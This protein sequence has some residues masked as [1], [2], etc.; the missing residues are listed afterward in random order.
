MSK[1]N[2]KDYGFE[3]NFVT[4]GEMEGGTE[5]FSTHTEKIHGTEYS[6]EVLMQFSLRKT[7]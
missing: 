6:N 5:K 3:Y 7:R 2:C 4:E 1:V